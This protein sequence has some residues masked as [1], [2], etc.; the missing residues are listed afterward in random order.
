VTSAH[1]I[2]AQA[3][4]ATSGD[5]ADAIAL[6][7]RSGL[8]RFASSEIH[9]P[10]LIENA[11]VILRIV[12]DGRIGA[13][14]TNRIDDDGLRDLATRAGEA[15][16]S[17]VAEA[18]FPGLPDPQSLP[19]VEGYDEALAD[20]GSDELARHARAAIDVERDVDVYGFVTSG[21]TELA[22]A[23]T[24]GVDV[25]QRM[26]D[27]TTLVVAAD[28]QASGYGEQ[29]TWSTAGFE[30]SAVG[31]E[32][33]QKAART[34]GA[35]P[36]EPA[37]YRAVL[38][39]YALADLIQYFGFD[40]FGAVGL[41]EER[42]YLAGR[43]DEKIMDEK[44]SIAD[45]GLDPR[46]LPKAF[47][48]EGVPK[49]RVQLI[50]DGVAR[51]VV[52]DRTTAARAGNGRES[53]G[54]A[55]PPVFRQYGPL[56]FSLS[57]AGGEAESTDELAELVGDGIYVTRLHYLGIVDQ[58]EGVLTG[59]TRDGTFRIRDGKV[60]EPLVNLRF[61]V[62]VPHVLADVP[63]LTREPKL[64]NS[65]DFYGERYPAGVLVPAIATAHFNITGV[66]S[67]PGV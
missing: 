3:L 6:A 33:A 23:S 13:A 31:A 34:R 50:E 39:P 55:P 14:M 5:D 40:A 27:A 10:T 7:E 22:I 18:D 52:W 57:M 61:T 20:L 62:A 8:A 43:L 25:S 59:M 51:G 30:P 36:V 44:V 58:R 4:A 28:E 54:H 64:C 32:A 65:S 67:E 17:A 49:Q 1:E 15:A 9:Q 19:Q 60:A 53:T 12:R 26:T 48:F 29:T 21:R 63:G 11:V 37:A 24:S 56:A 41:L 2:A 35:K 45:D 42:S 16:D 47:D 38:E 66:G 46:G